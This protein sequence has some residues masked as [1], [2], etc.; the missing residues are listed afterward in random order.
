MSR[1]QSHSSEALQAASTIFA[2]AAPEFGS[3]SHVRHRLENWKAK[4][5]A[6]YQDAYASLSVPAI[7]APFVRL[8]LLKW[9]PLFGGDIGM[10]QIDAQ[11]LAYFR[12][13]QYL[14][15]GPTACVC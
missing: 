7:F 15:F 12:R 1:F 11:G 3:L 2:D 4:Y 6:A 13:F 5:P 9:H 14:K 10:F 8:E